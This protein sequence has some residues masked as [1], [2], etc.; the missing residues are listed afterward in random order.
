MM[1]LIYWMLLAGVGVAVFFRS[2]T[3][4]KK[5]VMT[6]VFYRLDRYAFI[7]IHAAY[8]FVA[9]LIIIAIYLL[10]AFGLDVTGYA[11]IWGIEAYLHRPQ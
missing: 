3:V 4:A 10:G 8:Y 11:D 1:N 2:H 9:C 5:K 6:D 7:W